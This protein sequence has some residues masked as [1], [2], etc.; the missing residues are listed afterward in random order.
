MRKIIRNGRIVTEK[1][2]LSS[3][4]LVAANG[5]FEAI[6]PDD[7]TFRDDLRDGTEVIDA[8]GDILMPGMIDLHSDM[9]EQ[10]IQPR[11]T[12]LM[13]FEMALSEA[14]RLLTLCGITTMYH[15]VSMYRD[16]AW[17]VMEI[18][19]A[20]Q[21]KKLAALSHRRKAREKGLRHRFH[22]RYEIDNTEC[23]GE[24]E[25]MLEEGLVDLLSLTDHS[26]GQGQYRDLAV[27]RK[28]LESEDR[29]LDEGE[30][31]DR[32][33]RELDKSRVTFE[34][35]GQL[36]E[37][38]RAHGVPTASHDDD[39]LEK[40]G[41][42]QKL[43]VTISEFPIT[44]EVASE[45]VKRGF[46]TELGAP[47]ILLGGSHSGNLSAREAV[48]GGA[49]TIL[50]SDYYPQALLHS[51]FTLVEKY[52]HDLCDTVKLVTL[53]PARAVGIDEEY[54]SVREGKRCDLIQVRL[55]NGLPRVRRVWSGGK[56]I[57]SAYGEE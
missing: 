21:V 14:E 12:A 29:Q 48:E 36:V 19:K 57:L 47:N 28:H 22:L 34:Q 1:E 17:G 44:M 8:E 15:S 49:A 6:V 53:S 16:G 9:I 37:T 32:L 25:R 11:S 50:C 33:N 40:L 20:A 51:V 35:L 2:V 31:A 46:F 26:P 4:A 7:E 30:F 39:S 27:Y 55:E 43:G 42:N 3:H 41:V 23:F 5:R 45:A 56:E 54:G 13:D 18:R 38:A 52:G 10:L 24:V